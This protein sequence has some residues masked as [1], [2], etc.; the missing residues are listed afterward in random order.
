MAPKSYLSS[1]YYTISSFYALD[2]HLSSLFSRCNGLK[3]MGGEFGA[4]CAIIFIF[5]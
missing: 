1:L 5:G 2:I 3:M 4:I